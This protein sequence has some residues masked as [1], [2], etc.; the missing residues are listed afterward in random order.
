MTQLTDR[1]RMESSHADIL[2]YRSFLGEVGE[3]PIEETIAFL[4]EELPY[5]WRD[6]YREM[7]SHQ[8]N[9]IRMRHGAFEY[10][11]DDL[12]SLEASGAV[13]Y[14]LKAEARLVAVIGRSE[15]RERQRDDYRLRGWVGP[16]EKTFGRCWDKGHFI[17]HSIGGA[18][19]GMEM[20]VF[21]QR[22]DLNRGWSA[23]GKQFREMEKYCQS[24]PGTFCF[25]RPLYDDQ[26]AKPAYVE[27]GI[28]KSD[29]ELWVECFD[30]R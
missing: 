7:T 10:I 22:R 30:N 23:E 4:L 16:T 13:P 14:D 17:A 8:T 29:R 6:A 12:D 26:T 2:D 28:I 19:D 25:S 21:V 11:F 24:N 20:N 15:P 5:L 18:V 3:C 9:I 27:F 1:T